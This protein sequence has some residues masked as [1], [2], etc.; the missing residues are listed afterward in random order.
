METYSARKHPEFVVLEIGGDV[1][2]LI[3]RTGPD[4]HGEEIEISRADEDDRR[5]HKEVLE[6][7]IEGEPAFTAVFDGLRTGAYTLW[8]PGREPVRGVE[9]SGGSITQL[10]WRGN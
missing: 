9:I 6:R 7:S 4:L 1:G 8:A 5:S 3:L 10:D 2:A